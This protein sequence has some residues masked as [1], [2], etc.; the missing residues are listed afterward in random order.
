L[1]TIMP[2]ICG[3]GSLFSILYSLLFY[4]LINPEGVPVKKKPTIEFEIEVTRR[5]IDQ[6][7]R[8]GLTGAQMIERTV[9]RALQ[10]LENVGD[11]SLAKRRKRSGRPEFWW[12]RRR[13]PGRR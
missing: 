8:L 4:S 3:K 1:T 2:P 11:R 5:D 12:Q 7:H 9:E 10:K 13:T 6:A